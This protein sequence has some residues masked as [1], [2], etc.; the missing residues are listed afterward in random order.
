M[1]VYDELIAELRAVRALLERIDQRDAI[2]HPTRLDSTF[3]RVAS[4]QR[5]FVRDYR[6]RPKPLTEDMD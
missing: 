6:K 3:D 5:E 1:T 4:Y 2:V